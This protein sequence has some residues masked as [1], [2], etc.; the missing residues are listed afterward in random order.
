MSNRFIR[1]AKQR[2]FSAHSC[3]AVTR[4]S[5]CSSGL[6]VFAVLYGEPENRKVFDSHLFAHVHAHPL[7]KKDQSILLSQQVPKKV[8]MMIAVKIKRTEEERLR[9]PVA[10]FQRNI[11]PRQF[12]CSD[13]RK[14]SLY[15]LYKLRF[16]MGREERSARTSVNGVVC[17]LPRVIFHRT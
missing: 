17:C 13:K 10:R 5:T 6:R 7:R 4:S 16:G 2:K 8:R 1:P 14:A 9:G 12:V 11:P 3:K 15:V